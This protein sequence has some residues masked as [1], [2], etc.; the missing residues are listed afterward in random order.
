MSDSGHEN[1]GAHPSLSVITDWDD[2]Y[3]NTVH[4][5]GGE[6]YPEQ[7]NRRA[8]AFREAIQ[9]DGLAEF[10]LA[11]GPTER[12]R[13]DLFR[14][15]G[16]AKGLAV[17]VHGGFWMAFDKSSWSHLAAGALACGWAVAMPSYTLAPQ[18]R[19]SK[20]TR[21]VGDAVRFAAARIAGPIRLTGHSAGGH[22]V[23][24]IVCDDTPLPDDVLGRI[25]HV[26]SI[27][28]LH[29]L[30]PL[31]PTR[32]NQTLRL[33]QA[34]AA[35]ESAALRRPAARCS[36][37]CWVGSD[38]RPE[39]VRQNDLLANIWTGLGA[40]TCSVHAQGKHHFNV[41]E[42]LAHPASVLTQVLVGASTIGVPA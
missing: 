15:R 4:I 12:E 9:A 32:M 10:D 38:E 35:S 36:I 14:P 42:D 30:R 24:R 2:A 29:D 17:F 8:G 25:D 7:W 22:L 41:I 40:A 27:S 5:E 37:T 3:A 11:Y 19:I 33:D 20:I 21:Q 13:L 23:T 28:G 16:A 39:F 26:V 1:G 6:L 31:I 34:E 18:A